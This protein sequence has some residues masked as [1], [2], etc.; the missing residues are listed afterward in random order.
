MANLAVLRESLDLLEWDGE[1]PMSS[2]GVC[3][4]RCSMPPTHASGWAP[5]LRRTPHSPRDPQPYP[6]R[7][8]RGG[9]EGQAGC[10]TAA[11]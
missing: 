1:I 2:A 6:A 8:R 11:A 7:W 9:R 4:R 3:P 5:A 10:R